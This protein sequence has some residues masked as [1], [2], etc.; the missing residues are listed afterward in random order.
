MRMNEPIRTFVA[1]EVTRAVRERAGQLIERL[2]AS[3][4]SVRWVEVQNIHLTLKFLGNVDPRQIH[5]VCGAVAKAVAARPPFGMEARG[6]GAFPNA[7]RPRTLWL[8]VREGAEKLIELADSVEAALSPLGYPPEGR[9]FHPHITIGRV[10]GYS[11]GLAEL[12]QLV[13]KAEDFEAGRSPVGEVVV[14]ASQLERDGAR[15]EALSRAPLGGVA[16]Q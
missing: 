9:R 6:A 8:G 4:A 16:G 10:R 1:V 2:R 13:A 11:K 7:A 14:F 15:Y 5:E 12:A 3:Q